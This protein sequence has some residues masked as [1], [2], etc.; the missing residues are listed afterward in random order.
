MKQED[1]GALYMGGLT[2]HLVRQLKR[3]EIR[4]TYGE[5]TAD[6]DDVGGP[7]VLENKDEQPIITLATVYRPHDGPV[8]YIEGVGGEDAPDF[9]AR[10]DTIDE[11]LSELRL[12]II[13]GGGIVNRTPQGGRRTQ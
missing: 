9:L 3:G 1:H 4:L 11:A 13:E 2:A 7:V 5:L 8:W 12:D 10:G 6:V